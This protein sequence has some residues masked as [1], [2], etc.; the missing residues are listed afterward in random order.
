M[1]RGRSYKKSGID[2]R[3]DPERNLIICGIKAFSGFC[4]GYAD[5]V[6]ITDERFPGIARAGQVSA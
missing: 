6:G 4:A 1:K 2:P 3:S 5:N